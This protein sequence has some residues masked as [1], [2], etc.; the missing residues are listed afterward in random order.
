MAIRVCG[1]L[2]NDCPFSNVSIPGFLATYE[3]QDFVDFF[4]HDVLFPCHKT[5]PFESNVTT[6]AS[7]IKNGKL[8]LCRGYVECMAKSAKLPKDTEFAAIVNS[9]RKE[10]SESSM[11]F[12]QFKERHGKL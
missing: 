7:L 9:V 12:W 11:T 1:T 8:P 3:L 10:C 5:V 4:N 2:C 6:V